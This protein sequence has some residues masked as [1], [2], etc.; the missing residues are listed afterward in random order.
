MKKETRPADPDRVF[1]EVCAKLVPKSAARTAEA[2]GYV[3]YFC[4]QTCY[5]RWRGEVPPAPSMADVQEGRGRS[6]VRDDREKRLLKEHPQ[7]DE[8]KIDSVERDDVPR[9]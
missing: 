6:K 3:A 5:D 8:P 1:C 7:R 4:G 2:K 9:S